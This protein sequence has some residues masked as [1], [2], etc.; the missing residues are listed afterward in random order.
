MK[1]MEMGVIY[2]EDGQEVYRHKIAER[3]IEP[4]PDDLKRME[5]INREMHFIENFTAPTMSNCNKL[6]DL[7]NE[8]M[9]LGVKNGLLHPIGED[10]KPKLMGAVEALRELP[11]GDVKP[12]QELG[13]IPSTIMNLREEIQWLKAMHTEDF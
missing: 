9:E 4:N 2:N 7:H 1:E 10:R 13:I 11:P 3:T 5:D 8:L 12:V 6:F